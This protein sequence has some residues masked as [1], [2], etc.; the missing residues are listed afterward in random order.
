METLQITTDARGV[1]R[2]LM[3]RPEVFNAFNEAMIAELTDTFD[4]LGR[5][6]PCG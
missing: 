1:A 5:I 2:V 4:R 3:N 6:P